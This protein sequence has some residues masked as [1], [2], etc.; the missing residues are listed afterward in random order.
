MALELGMRFCRGASRVCAHTCDGRVRVTQGQDERTSVSWGAVGMSHALGHVQDRGLRSAGCPQLR[1]VG[2][3]LSRPWPQTQR[4]QLGLWGSWCPALSR[5]EGLVL[6]VRV[7]PAG[8]SSGTQSSERA[9]HVHRE[10]R[11]LANVLRAS[12][13]MCTTAAHPTGDWRAD[14]TAFNFTVLMT[15][16]L[17]PK[18]LCGVL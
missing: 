11:A 5:P 13:V 4:L 9:K 16:L 7:H 12:A 6:A 8:L 14:A 15:A 17:R 2:H 18:Q 1:A 3:W 10:S